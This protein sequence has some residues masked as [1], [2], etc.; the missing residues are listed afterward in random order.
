MSIRY[1]PAAEAE[2]LQAI[3]YY[4]DIERETAQSFADELHKAL[5]RMIELPKA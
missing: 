3:D 4:Q 5:D 2:V 1:H